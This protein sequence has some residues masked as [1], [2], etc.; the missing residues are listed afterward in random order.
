MKEALSGHEGVGSL[1]KSI[2]VEKEKNSELS[3]LTSNSTASL[4]GSDGSQRKKLQQL[5]VSQK[6]DQWADECAM[7]N[8]YKESHF[9][10]NKFLSRGGC[11]FVKSKKIKSEFKGVGPTY[12]MIHLHVVDLKSIGVSPT[13]RGPEGGIPPHHYKSLC[14]AF[15][16]K[17]CICQLNT[18]VNTCKKQIQWIKTT[19][20][21]SEQE[22]SALWK[23]L[24][25]DS[26][27]DIK[28][29][30]KIKHAEE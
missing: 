21:C 10:P 20:Q 2:T 15:A 24:S 27:L 8:K 23:R 6:Q 29:T 17:T 4:L 22:A 3:P 30:G 13:K 12:E 25:W 5:T 28:A 14:M 11:Q 19:L 16:T 1:V 9:M 18:E 26:A 7:W